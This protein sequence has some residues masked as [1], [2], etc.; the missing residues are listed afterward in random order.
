MSLT[1]THTHLRVVSAAEIDVG[2][3]RSESDSWPLMEL[4]PE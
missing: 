2:G 3:D 1:D 4:N